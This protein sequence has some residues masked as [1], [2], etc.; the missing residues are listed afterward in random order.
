MYMKASNEQEAATTMEAVKEPPPMTTMAPVASAPE[1]S[2]MQAFRHPSLN[3]PVH[4]PLSQYAPTPMYHSVDSVSTVPLVPVGGTSGSS[5]VGGTPAPAPIG[6]VPSPA[7]VETTPTPSSSRSFGLAGKGPRVVAGVSRPMVNRITK[8]TPH[9]GTASTAASSVSESLPTS[10]SHSTLT[11]LPTP[12]APFFTPE[13]I[14]TP[15]APLPTPTPL[16]TSTAPPSTP[17][18]PLSTPVP[19]QAPTMSTRKPLVKPKPAKP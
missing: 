14:I 13:A 8:Y 16:S 6:I 9:S 7:P 10:V 3:R 4:R 2:V 1:S 12:T 17:T 15:V 5:L 18:A 11:P 19:S